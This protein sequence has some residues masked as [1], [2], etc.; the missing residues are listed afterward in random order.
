MGQASIFQ[1]TG[2]NPAD[3]FFSSWLDVSAIPTSV[4]GSCPADYLNA[5]QIASSSFAEGGEKVVTSQR[6][7]VDANGNFSMPFGYSPRRPGRYLLC[8]Y[9]NDGAT[10]TLATSS[11][12]L[13]VVGGGAGLVH[14]RAGANGRPRQAGESRASPHRSPGWQARVPA[15]DMVEQPKW[16]RL[17]LVRRRQ[18]AAR[19]QELAAQDHP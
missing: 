19:C 18:A 6:E 16:L 13:N 2:S 17:S 3:D 11:L 9:T 7:T 14:H 4:L 15:R 8:A 1:A 5:S 10:T 12:I